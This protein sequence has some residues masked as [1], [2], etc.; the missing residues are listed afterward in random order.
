MQICP[1]IFFFK[2][3]CSLFVIRLVPDT[4]SVGGAK[5]VFAAARLG[6]HVLPTINVI[7]V[8]S[9]TGDTINAVIVRCRNEC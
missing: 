3:I 8:Y 5:L 9:H 6:L 4:R 2:F 7:V 1:V